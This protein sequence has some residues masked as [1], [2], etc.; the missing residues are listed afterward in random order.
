[1]C[2]QEGAACAVR[3]RARAFVCARARARVLAFASARARVSD[4]EPARR[5]ATYG[6]FRR[7]SYSTVGLDGMGDQWGELAVPYFGG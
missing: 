5:F 4:R 1:M 3:A 6:F 2:G 7:D